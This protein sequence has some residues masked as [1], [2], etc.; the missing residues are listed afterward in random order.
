MKTFYRTF[1]KD[2]SFTDGQN[3]IEYKKGDEVLTTQTKNGVCKVLDRFWFNCESK[4][5]KNVIIFTKQ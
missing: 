2:M 3:T 1:K 5:F 4:Y